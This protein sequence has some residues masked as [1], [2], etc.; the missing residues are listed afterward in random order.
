MDAASAVTGRRSKLKR[1]GGHPFVKENAEKRGAP[2][3]R[4]VAHLFITEI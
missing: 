2:F 4:Q 1:A 3:F